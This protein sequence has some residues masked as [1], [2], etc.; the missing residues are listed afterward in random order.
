[1]LPTHHPALGLLAVIK[2][3]RRKTMNKSLLG[4]LVL[5]AAPAC[6]RLYCNSK[7]FRQRQVRDNEHRKP[8]RR[9]PNFQSQDPYN[10]LG[11]H[12]SSNMDEIKAA[13]V[14]LALEYHPDTTTTN[15]SKT[16]SVDREED[17]TAIFVKVRHAFEQILI[18][19]KRPQDK[20]ASPF[21]NA[22]PSREEWMEWYQQETGDFLKF[23][24]DE[25]T[26]REVI[27]VY[28]TMQPSGKDKGGYWDMARML[29]EREELA[30]NEHQED[31]FLL[32]VKQIGEGTDSA[33]LNRRRRRR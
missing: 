14:E 29:A 16:S 25:Q 32:P 15:R 26:R 19:S 22:S 3:Y 12:S 9:T 8:L 7:H 4:L 31:D 17:R 2:G 21:Q 6:R 20:V 5:P 24:M 33:M 13:F 11:I 30:G 1:M 28:K 10:V 27:H 23:Q 18:R